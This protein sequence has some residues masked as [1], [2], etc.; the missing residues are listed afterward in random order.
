[1]PSVE[2]SCDSAYSTAVHALKPTWSRCS[3]G[4]IAALDIALVVVL[5][6]DARDEGDVRIPGTVCPLRQGER[7][8]GQAATHLRSWIVASVSSILRAWSSIL[9]LPW[10]TGLPGLGCLLL[11]MV[12][13]SA[14]IVRLLRLLLVLMGLLIILSRIG[15]AVQYIYAV[16]ELEGDRGRE[17]GMSP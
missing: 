9:S 6:I 10:R 3:V 17:G 4:R 8:S 12:A 13:A 14:A 1:M 15:H 7:A 5:R 16:C 11:L 2:I